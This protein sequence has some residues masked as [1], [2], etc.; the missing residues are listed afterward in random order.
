M[1][2][3]EFSEKEVEEGLIELVK[4]GELAIIFTPD[5]VPRYINSSQ[6]MIKCPKCNCLINKDV[7][8][9]HPTTTKKS[10]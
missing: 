8:H 1:T 10:K 5:D 7:K 4:S 6:V 3:E 9:K 2:D